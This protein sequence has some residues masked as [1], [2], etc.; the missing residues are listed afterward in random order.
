MRLYRRGFDINKSKKV[1][2]DIYL[3]PIFPALE[4]RDE[5]EAYIGEEADPVITFVLRR[6]PPQQ[7]EDGSVKSGLLPFRQKEAFALRDNFFAIQSAED[8]LRFFQEYGPYQL[9]KHLDMETQPVKLSQVLRRRDFYTHALFER[10]IKNMARNYK[11]EEVRE[12]FE[13]MYLWGNLPMELVFRQPMGAIVRCKDVE[14]AL[15][16]TVFLDKL[17]GLPWKRCA[18]KDCGKPFEV[19]GKRERLY[20][21]PECAHLQSVRNYNAKQTAMAVKATK[22][23]VKKGKR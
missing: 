17:R 21:S 14:D 16:A 3:L 22:P 4:T 12:A 11:G 23:A 9:A 6:R 15:R 18:R 8:A 10:S 19:K 5:W 20:C 7:L 2:K 13:N 1:S